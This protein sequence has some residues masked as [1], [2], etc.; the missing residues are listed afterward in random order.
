MFV[1]LHRSLF[2]LLPRV[3]VA[4]LVDLGARHG[5]GPGRLRGCLEGGKAALEVE[6]NTERARELGLRGTPTVVLEGKAYANPSWD[7]LT[8]VVGEL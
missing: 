4:S 1:E 2:D 7:T 3:D 8:G 5:A 6:H